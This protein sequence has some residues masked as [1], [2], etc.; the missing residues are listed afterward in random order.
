MDE[1]VKNYNRAKKDCT[2]TT[3]RWSQDLLGT[4]ISVAQLP[5]VNENIINMAI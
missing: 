3:I 4:Y 2:V 1:A 5:L